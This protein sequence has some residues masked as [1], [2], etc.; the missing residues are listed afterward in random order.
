MA[1]SAVAIGLT[2]LAFFPY[3]RSVLRGCGD[4]APSFTRKSP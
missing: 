3:I 2:L 1:L 4:K